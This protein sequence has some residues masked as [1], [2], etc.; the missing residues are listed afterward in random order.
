MFCPSCNKKFDDSLGMGLCDKCGTK[1]ETQY[2]NYSFDR[3]SLHG[4]RHRPAAPLRRGNSEIEFS[5]E[6]VEE[7]LDKIDELETKIDEIDEANNINR[8]IIEDI[9]K[10][11]Q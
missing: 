6:F 5:S 9:R 4:V 2:E 11:F 1:L 3:D 10:M 8:E 7:I